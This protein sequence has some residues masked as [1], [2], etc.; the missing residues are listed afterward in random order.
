[1]IF[2]LFR[3][4]IFRGICS[5]HPDI[6]RPEGVGVGCECCSNN[7]YRF[8]AHFKPKFSNITFIICSFW[9]STHNTTVVLPCCVQNFKTIGRLRDKLWTNDISWDLRLG[10]VSEIYSLLQQ[11]LTHDDVIKWKHFPR[12]WPLC[13]EFTGHRWIPLTKA[14]DAELWCFLWSAP[15]INGW[16]NNRETG[17]LRRHGAHYDVIVMHQNNTLKL[18][19]DI[20]SGNHRCYCAKCLWQSNIASNLKGHT[21]DRNYLIF[22]WISIKHYLRTPVNDKFSLAYIMDWCIL[23][24]Q[25]VI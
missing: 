25:A 14:S 13:G 10:S 22:Y 19:R 7:G 1:M 5:S 18:S 24:E 4:C 17:D 20:C 11:P 2:R 6:T 3:T 23:E 12:H 15:L 21:L 9:D 16:V 8:G